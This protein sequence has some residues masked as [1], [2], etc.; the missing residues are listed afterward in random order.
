MAK[1]EVVSY[2]DK[3]YQK[4]KALYDV[5]VQCMEDIKYGTH[6]SQSSWN[7]PVE[8]I[9]GVTYRLVGEGQ[10]ELTYH[11]YEVTTVEG[12]ARGED[13]GKRF[14]K[15]VVKQLKKTFKEYTGK[16]LTLKEIK[17]GSGVDKVSRITAD[18]SWML[19]SSRY[20]HGA[21]PVGRY[22]V[23]DSF[24]YEFSANL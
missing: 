22:L 8:H 6:S 4:K 3:N 11:R 10:L 15:E 12:L 16:A 13:D 17:V 9:K 1:S 21:R 24:L 20:G 7:M 5:V 14:M 19:G 2:A 18:S 23:K